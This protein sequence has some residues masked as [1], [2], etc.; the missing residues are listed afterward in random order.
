MPRLQSEAPFLSLERAR[1]RE[2]GSKPLDMPT[3]GGGVAGQ[4]VVV[5]GVKGVNMFSSR[6]DCTKTGGFQIHLLNVKR[7]NVE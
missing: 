4:E 2:G 7:L 3:I 6:P 5:E 1:E